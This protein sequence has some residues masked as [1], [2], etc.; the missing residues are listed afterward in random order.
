M[1]RDHVQAASV[2]TMPESIQELMVAVARV[3]ELRPQLVMLCD[4]RYAKS[5][6]EPQGAAF[7]FAVAPDWPIPSD[8]AGLVQYAEVCCQKWLWGPDRLIDPSRPYYLCG[9][10]QSC[11]TAFEIGQQMSLAGHRPTAVILIG[12]IE[13]G[14]ASS[15][16]SESTKAWDAIVSWLWAIREWRGQEEPDANRRRDDLVIRRA[17]Q[18]ANAEVAGW[19]RQMLAGRRKRGVELAPFPVFE[20][21]GIG[22]TG[23]SSWVEERRCQIRGDVRAI[24]VRRAPEVN[25]FLLKILL[26]PI[27]GGLQLSRENRSSARSSSETLEEVA[28]QIAEAERQLAE[29]EKQLV[30]VS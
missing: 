16:P 23:V 11:S 5:I 30:S 10:G 27:P 8:S 6:L 12:A 28:R 21:D 17:L 4:F 18:E 25:A 20:L 2:R 1:S 26:S 9:F 29:A 15:S 24:N 19:A 13:G 7:P 14:S 3:R 22:E